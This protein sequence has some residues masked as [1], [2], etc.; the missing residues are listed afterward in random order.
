[1]LSGDL[2]VDELKA[3][4]AGDADVLF[5][6]FDDLADRARAEGATV[7]YGNLTE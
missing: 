7:K 4:E 5:D 2:I 6:F 3:A 1:V